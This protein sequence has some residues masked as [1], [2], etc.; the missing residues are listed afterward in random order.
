MEVIGNDVPSLLPYL[1]LRSEA[2]VSIHREK[3]VCKF[4]NTTLFHLHLFLGLTK[5]CNTMILSRGLLQDAPL[6]G[7]GG[8]KNGY[9]EE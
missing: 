9:L 2:L 8:V 1:F 3:R 6:R 4:M 7:R 5:T